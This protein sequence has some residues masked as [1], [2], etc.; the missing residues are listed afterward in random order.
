MAGAEVP[1][2][3]RAAVAIDPAPRMVAVAANRGGMAIARPRGIHV[4][5]HAA[6]TLLDRP[7]RMLPARIERGRVVCDLLRARVRIWD[8]RI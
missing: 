7:Q 2:H 1:V 5:A 6:A 3:D 4:R 8:P